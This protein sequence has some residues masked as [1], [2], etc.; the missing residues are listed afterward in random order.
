[1]LEPEGGIIATIRLTEQKRSIFL[2]VLKTAS[3]TRKS[4]LI[5]S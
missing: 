5:V 2:P 3:L 1:M 4:W